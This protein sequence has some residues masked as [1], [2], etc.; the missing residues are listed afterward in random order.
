MHTVS[1]KSDLAASLVG[2]LVSSYGKSSAFHSSTA[3]CRFWKQLRG[4]SGWTHHWSW[5]WTH[6][7]SDL[8]IGSPRCHWEVVEISPPPLAIYANHG[9]SI[10]GS[11]WD[12]N[13]HGKA[14]K[15]H[16]ACLSITGFWHRI[17]TWEVDSLSVWTNTQGVDVG[18]R[19]MHDRM[20]KPR[21][22]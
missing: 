6:K 22:F 20:E 16:D 8:E 19:C 13:W 3:F 11:I 18:W 10:H 15:S 2:N 4:W 17:K 12:T 1:W 7:H 5:V 9:L 14:R 21:A